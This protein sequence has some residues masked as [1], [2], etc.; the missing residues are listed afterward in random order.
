MTKK[1]KYIE[2]RKSWFPAIHDSI[3]H[4]NAVCMGYSGCVDA[5]E[6]ALCVRE[7]PS[8]QFNCIVCPLKRAGKGCEPRRSLWDMYMRCFP[9][10]VFRSDECFCSVDSA[11]AAEAMLEA[12]VQLLPPEERKRYEL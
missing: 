5:S 11:N 7:Q 1:K 8:L 10:E 4:W 6:C 9:T 3:A 2:T 12:L